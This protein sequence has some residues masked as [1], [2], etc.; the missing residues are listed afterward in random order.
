MGTQAYFFDQVERYNQ[1]L[2]FYARRYK[3]CHIEKTTELI[4]DGTPNYLTYHDRVHN[5]Y[6]Y[7]TSETLTKLKIVMVLTEPLY[8][9]KRVYQFKRY[10]YNQ[11]ADKK[12]SWFQ[13]I[14]DKEGGVLSF[15]QYAETVL[16]AHLNRT[17]MGYASEGKYV[18]H[19][20][21]WFQ[22]FPR[23]QFLLVHHDELEN[24]PKSVQWRVEKFL[25]AELTGSLGKAHD[26]TSVTPR[27]QR[28]LGPLFDVKNQELYDFLKSNRGPF[29]EQN[30]FPHFEVNV[31]EFS[32]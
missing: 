2:E 17:N 27:V 7:G 3:H 24:N 5:I 23:H 9:E 10:S 29:M 31:K 4:V 19:L 16:V 12:S 6:Q 28:A 21:K 18:N 8:R 22:Y 1:G 32:K 30:P 13:D 20:R 11:A 14:L 25:G 15:E 26:D